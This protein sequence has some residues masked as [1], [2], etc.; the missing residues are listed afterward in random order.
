MA[1]ATA[2]GRL[3]APV[4]WAGRLIA[5]HRW[6]AIVLALAVALRLVVMLGYPPI[7]WFN[8]SYNYVTD[9][10]T[11]TPDVVRS[12][13]YPLVLWLLLPFH[14]LTLIAVL[15]ALM[16]LAMGVGIYAVLR[17]RGLPWWGAT[18]PALPVLFDV[19]ELLLEHMVMSDVLFTFLITVALVALCWSDQPSL[20]TCTIVGLVIGFAAIVRAVG[21]PLL[22]VV[23]V[24]LLARRVNWKRTAA[25]LV[26]GLLPIAGYMAWYHSF[27]GQYALDTSSGTFLYSRVSTFAQCA[28]MPNLASDLRVLCDPKPPSQRSSSQQYLWDTTTPLYRLTKGNNFTEQANSLAGKFAKAA[29]LAQPGDYAADV[30]D[31]TMHTFTWDRSQSDLTGSG[32]SYQFR[33]TVD[34][35]PWWANYYPEDKA[36]LIEYGGPTEGQPTVVKSWSSIIQGYQNVFYLRG[37]MLG[38][39]LA[40]GLGGVLLRWR[41]WGGL[42]LLP[43]AVGLVLVV[44][45]PMTSGFSYRYVLAA[46]PAAC[47]AA[48]LACTREPRRSRKAVAVAVAARQQDEEHAPATS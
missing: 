38:A 34:P 4:R 31:D 29:I 46:V 44:L 19:Y 33:A 48:G 43:W 6:F 27:Y 30:W 7:L 1:D 28:K 25:M 12:N 14:S 40:I 2:R 8:D 42:T 39:I 16:G 15:Q 9:A 22:I 3:A 45:P 17:R 32:P 21:E 41:R 20:L 24:L 5:A 26:V 18:L 13:G 10:V 47:L 36:A 35:M 37:T 23:A 11:K